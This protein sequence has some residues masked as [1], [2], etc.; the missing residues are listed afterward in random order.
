MEDGSVQCW[1]RD[2]SQYVL[3]EDGV[4]LDLAP[5]DVPELGSDNLAVVTG[6]MHTCVLKTAGTVECLGFNSKGQLG[7]GTYDDSAIPVEVIGLG[8]PVEGLVAGGYSNC[9]LL[10]GGGVKCWGNGACLGVGS[11][12]D[13][14]ENSPTPLTVH[15]LG[16]GVA[17]ISSEFEHVCVRLETGS[18]WCWGAAAAGQCGNGTTE[19]QE[20]WW[21]SKV[22]GL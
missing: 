1:G 21:P 19:E 2:L 6:T 4:A 22:E 13:F 10:K 20:V 7:D 15:G 3:D 16:L 18:V 17:T 14:P 5:E 12:Y 8:L 9:A 11:D